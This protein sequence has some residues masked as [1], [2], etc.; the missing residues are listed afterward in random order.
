VKKTPIFPLAN[1]GPLGVL[2]AIAAASAL[3]ILGTSG[4]ANAW[5]AA[6]LLPL[7]V[8]LGLCHRRARRIVNAEI[9][10]EREIVV[11]DFVALAAERAARFWNLLFSATIAAT[12][13]L[14]VAIWAYQ[15]FIS[16]VGD[17]WIHLTWLEVLPNIQRAENEYL[18]R[19]IYWIGDTNL[20]VVVLIIGLLLAAPLAAISW[21]SNNKARIRR[22]EL[23]NL[24][25]RS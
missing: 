2:T 14:S 19:L 18:N 23:G 25:K 1:L 24:K 13:V 12:G 3:Y 7:A 21:R 20:G 16:Y 22:N 11:M 9:G 6:G 4:V 17:R 10:R 8:Y 15:G 5:A